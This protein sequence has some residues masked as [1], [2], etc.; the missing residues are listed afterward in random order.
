MKNKTILSILLLLA[1]AAS[2]LSAGAFAEGESLADEP[3]GEVTVETADTLEE[4]SRE[5][6][7]VE[8]TEESGAEGAVDTAEATEDVGE[9]SASADEPAAGV[10]VLM[11]IPY[12]EFYAA[13]GPEDVDAVTSVTL[14]KPRTIGL[15]G[16]SY[17]VNSDGS[18]ISGVIYPVYVSDPSLLEG[19]NEV[20]EESSVTI[21]VT[22]R[23]TETETVLEGSDAL[24]EA[25]SYSYYVL[26]EEPALYKTMY[27]D[28]SFSAVS[29]GARVV[30][31][32][33][34]EV[35]YNGRH[36][37]IEISLE[38]LDG[39]DSSTRVSAV[40]VTDEAGNVYGMRHVYNIWRSS[41]LGWNDDEL[42]LYGR[43]ITRIRYYTTDD[44]VDYPVSIA[45][46]QKA[47]TTLTVSFST[48][49]TLVIEGLPEDIRNPRVSV[50][51]VVGRGETPEVLAENVPFAGGALT[52]SEST[53]DGTS[54]NVTVVSDNY[55]DLAITLEKTMERSVAIDEDG[56]IARVNGTASGCYARVA[57]VLDMN[58]VSGL[59]VQQATIN[60]DG[61][62]VIPQF[63]MPG[64][65]VTGVSVVLAATVEEI[66]APTPNALASAFRM[67]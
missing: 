57:L 17:H 38:G 16:G 39:I 7:A 6:E 15:A 43:T 44:V 18:D 58:G 22:N 34:G 61:S 9:T 53:L 25:S 46:K 19:L 66:T 13:E 59:L 12:A 5:P 23:G 50:S 20:T 33:T 36:K 35:T 55:A 65:T 11:N 30:E 64:V 63:M 49:D 52:L 27:A 67:F 32:V 14:N 1:L 56:K 48:P 4:G 10:Y 60:D 28:G 24:F 62:I 47:E 37:N 29:K 26:A 51:S 42:D 31:G 2:L 21:V 3:A 40:A 45:L 54:Y 41:Q 8:D